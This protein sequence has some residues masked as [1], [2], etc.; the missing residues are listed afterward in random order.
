MHPTD[1]QVVKATSSISEATVTLSA[2]GLPGGVTFT[3]A[4]GTIAYTTAVTVETNITIKATSN[5][6]ATAEITIAIL[7]SGAVQENIT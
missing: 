6:G 5:R 2:T 7:P 3:A 1:T 4:T